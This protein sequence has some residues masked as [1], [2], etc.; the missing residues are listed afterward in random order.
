MPAPP[1][2]RSVAALR[3]RVGGW[4]SEGARVALVPTM[5]ALHAGHTALIEAA[6]RSADRTVVSIFVNPTQ[7][8]ANEDYGRYPRDEAADRALLAAAGVEAVFAP[9]VGEM[10]PAGAATA[11]TVGGPALGLESDFRPQLFGGVATAVARLLMVCQPDAAIFG[12][13]DYQQLLVIRRMVSDLAIPVDIVGHPTVR[14]EDGLAHSSRNAYLSAGERRTAPRLYRALR[15]AA[16]AMR[17]GATPQVATAAVER[18]L[19]AAGFA[20]DYVAL[21]H[22]GTLAPVADP[23]SEPIR[24]LAA[25]RLGATRLIDNVAV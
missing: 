14:G 3:S 19:A 20:I 12:E 6:R 10:Y 21:R 15:E 18:D 5:G 23:T 1:V 25:A 8:G 24:L 22:A 2:D 4:R 17:A 9:P 13:K 16:E 7:F 11:I